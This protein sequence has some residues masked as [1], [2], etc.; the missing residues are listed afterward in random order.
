MSV[1]GLLVQSGLGLQLAGG[2]NDGKG[3]GI[4]PA[5]R[6]SQSVALRVR[7][8]NRSADVLARRCSVFRRLFRVVEFRPSSKAGG[9]F[10]SVT[11]MVTVMVSE[12]SDGS[13]AFTVTV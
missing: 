8:R 1:L 7:G 2:C 5:E 12:S 13:A 3:R 11:V 6:I 9:S 10:T 4:R